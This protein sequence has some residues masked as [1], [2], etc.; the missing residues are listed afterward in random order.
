MVGL[1]IWVLAFSEPRL[2]AATLYWDANGT[3]PGAAVGGV[4]SGTWG[5]D[6]FWSTD[7]AGLLSPSLLN[8]TLSDDLFFAAG[9]DAIGSSTLTISGG[10]QA[11]SLTFTAG[12]VSLGGAAT[13][14]LTLGAGGLTMDSTMGGSLTLGASLGGVVLGSSQTWSNHSGQQLVVQ[15]AVSGSAAVGATTTWTVGGSGTGLITVAG[16]IGNGSSG[17]ALALTKT[18]S[19]TL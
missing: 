12:T 7:V 19:G 6:S 11:N 13:P 3:S 17:G 8:T 1:L 14:V 16:A 4:A 15:T 5:V 10:Q 2:Q 9:S 18:G